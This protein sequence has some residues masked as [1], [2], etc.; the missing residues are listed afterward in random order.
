MAN[1]ECHNQMVNLH[2]PMGFPMVFWNS[3]SIGGDVPGSMFHLGARRFF[4]NV[5]GQHGQHGLAMARSQAPSRWLQWLSWKQAA[6]S[7]PMSPWSPAGHLL[8][9]NEVRG[10]AA[11]M[12][13][14]L[15]VVKVERF[16]RNERPSCAH[17]T[18]KVDQCCVQ[19]VSSKLVFFSYVV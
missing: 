1:C 11:K 2:F 18:S 8:K 19:L 14:I 7:W 16:Q 10:R 4:V 12:D 9:M 6:G 5:R 17:A 3:L 13:A 15:W